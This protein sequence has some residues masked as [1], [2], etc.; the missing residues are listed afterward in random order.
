MVSMYPELLSTSDVMDTAGRLY[1]AVLIDMN[2]YENIA[3][4]IMSHCIYSVRGCRHGIIIFASQSDHSF[5]SF[6]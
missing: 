2:T 3:I 4:S 5:E 6:L 1:L